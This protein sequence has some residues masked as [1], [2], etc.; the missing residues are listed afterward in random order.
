MTKRKM[1][2]ETEKREIRIDRSPPYSPLPPF[3]SLPSL[4]ASFD[5]IE[6]FCMSVKMFYLW[7]THGPPTP[8][9]P[10][11]P[12]PNTHIHPASHL[13]PNFLTLPSFPVAA[14]PFPPP[15]KKW[16]TGGERPKQRSTYFMRN[17]F[18]SVYLT[19]RLRRETEAA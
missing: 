10:P 7:D 8:A 4:L 15:F 6:R 18:D 5:R 14:L 11:P 3:S 16:K 1:E 17:T 2:K 19:V 13:S 9:G 12:P